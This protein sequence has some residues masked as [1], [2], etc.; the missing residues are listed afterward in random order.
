MDD[1]RL[2]FVSGLFFRTGCGVARS[3]GTESLLEAAASVVGVACIL[4]CGKL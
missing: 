1:F 3:Y 2:D 4:L